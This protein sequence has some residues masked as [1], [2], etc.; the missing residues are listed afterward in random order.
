MITNLKNIES[1]LYDDIDFQELRKFSKKKEKSI[2]HIICK[3]Y[4]ELT[5]S[6]TLKFFLDPNEEHNLQEYFLKQFLHSLVKNNSETLKTQNIN[7]IEFDLIDLKTAKVFREYTIGDFGRLDIFIEIAGVL[8]I[9]IECKMYSFEG[10]EQTKR[11]DD[12]AR[13]TDDPKIKTIKCYLSPDGHSPA[14]PHFLPLS[15]NEIY[16][17]FEDESI[18]KELSL[19]K[20]FLLKNFKQWLLDYMEQKQ[21]IIDKCRKI[22]SKYK[23]E[24]DLIFSVM[25]TLKS[26]YSSVRDK[27]NSKY[28]SD[29]LA[30][31]GSYWMSLS[32]KNWLAIEKLKESQKATILRFEIDSY[33]E[34]QY[35]NLVS[36][37]SGNLH[38]L[39][40]KT[41]KKTLQNETKFE[42]YKD[43]GKKFYPLELNES[44]NPEN[45]VNEWEKNIEEYA[46]KSIKYMKTIESSFDITEI[47]KILNNT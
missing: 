44:F 47:I 23:V 12:W 46:E 13:E 9:I 41:Y 25:P 29:Y 34:K 14:S 10:D 11:Y 7:R 26:F 40:L 4:D 17:M 43:W 45:I 21:E 35:L 42:S 16:D 8:R 27:I 3:E 24:F 1:L 19:D 15:Y 39:I 31:S 38:D 18:I 20:Q 6:R 5:F 28:S 36:P 32:P 33:G 22:Y 2:F 37:Q 30:H